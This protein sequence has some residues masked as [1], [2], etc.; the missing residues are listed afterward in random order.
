MAAPEEYELTVNDSKE[1]WWATTKEYDLEID[2]QNITVRIAENPK[3]TEFFEW[4]AE[5]GFSEADTDDGL[6]A[7]V[8]ESWSN[9]ELE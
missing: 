6:M 2:G 4:D 8:Y 5:S 9:G 3:G 7:I 1:V